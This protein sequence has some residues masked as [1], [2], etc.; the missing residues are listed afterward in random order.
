MGKI[1]KSQ[2]Y[3]KPPLNNLITNTQRKI[4]ISLS[5]VKE[6]VHFL[7]SHAEKPPIGLHFVGKRRISALHAQLFN[8]PSP[9]DCITVPY[10]ESDFL[11]EVFVC[12]EI[13]QEYVKT[14]GGDL[15]YEITLY[16]IHGFLHLLGFKDQTA[17]ER[18]KMRREEKKWM[19]LLAKNG[20]GVRIE[21]G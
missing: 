4:P 12:P 21:T 3:L 9:T 18:K 13:A 19:E 15:A 14:H 6:L 10:N 1:K 7:S 17:E 11:G 20:L 16:L 8:D 5:S 2:D